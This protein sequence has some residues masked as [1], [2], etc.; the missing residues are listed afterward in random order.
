NES[1]S[2][3]SEDTQAPSQVS[4]LVASEVTSSNVGLTWL[5]ASDNVGVVNYEIER[6]TGSGCSNFVLIGNTGSLSFEDTTVA[7]SI[8]YRY[9]VRAID[10]SGNN[11]SY[12]SIV[13]ITTE[14][15][16]TEVDTTP[17]S[18]VMGLTN[19]SLTGSSVTLSWSAASDNVG[20]SSYRIYRCSGQE[21]TPT[22][23]IGIST[24][25]VYVD[26]TVTE[27]SFYSYSVQAYDAAG[28]QGPMSFYLDILT[29]D[30]SPALLSGGSPSGQLAAGTSQITLQVT[31]NEAATCR[32]SPVSGTSYSTMIP[33]SS[34]G[35]F[36]H[37]TLVS[38]LSDGQ[39]YSYYVKC[40]DSS[41]NRNPDDY[42]IS[43]SVGSVPSCHLSSASWSSL[44][45][46][47]GE[48]VE[49]IVSGTNCD[50]K[51]LTITIY[52]DDLLDTTVMTLSTQF[53]GNQALA[54]WISEWECDGNLFG[55]CTAGNPEYYFVAVL[56]ENVS[57]SISSGTDSPSEL[58]VTSS[59]V[60]APVLYDVQVAVGSTNATVSWWTDEPSQSYLEY[61]L[62]SSYGKNTSLSSSLSDS[63]SVSVTALD[64][65]TLYYYKL[66]SL[67]QSGNKGFVVGSFRTA[68]VDTVSP[69]LISTSP[70]NGSSN[71]SISSD[72]YF[73][74][75][76]AMS[77][78]TLSVTNDE[79]VAFSSSY[80]NASRSLK[81]SPAV[82][83]EY[84]T[85]YHFH[86]SALGT[87]LAGN[88]LGSGYD[89]VFT[90]DSFDE[91][92]TVEVIFNASTWNMSR[93]TNFSALNSSELLSVGDAIFSNQY[94]EIAFLSPLK[95]ERTLDL[96]DKISVGAG[97]A[98]LDSF[99]LPEFNVSA[100]LT[101]HN[102][103]YSKYKVQRDGVDCPSS[104]CSEIVANGTSLSFTVTSWSEYT[105]VEVS[106]SS[107]SGGSSSSSGGGGGGSSNSK[108][109]KSSDLVELAEILGNETGT[110]SC[111]SS[112][113]YGQWSVCVNGEQSRLVTD[114]AACVDVETQTR[115]CTVSG[116]EDSNRKLNAK[117]LDLQIVSSK[118]Y[119]T[120]LSGTYTE[121]YYVDEKLSD[122]SF[123]VYDELSG[124]E[125]LSEF[126]EESDGNYYYSLRP[127]D[128]VVVS[129]VQELAAAQV[130]AEE[131]A[132]SDERE[133]QKYFGQIF[134][135]ATWTVLFLILVVVGIGLIVVYLYK[136]RN[137][138]E[139]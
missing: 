78:G 129:E 35:A 49:A 21:C 18:Q 40:S 122:E 108:K 67:D 56:S 8:S 46:Q 11:G 42:Q 43:F 94:G 82:D 77:V 116:D 136:R 31:S 44:L 91:P 131:Q 69:Q 113:E 29:P 84:E 86:L 52:E 80:D 102:I 2:N 10:A 110:E 72:I 61:G 22:S 119:Q 26:S 133:K 73:T 123:V 139:F 128:S 12:S 53:S 9:R 68:Y 100:R 63:H 90:T 81:L 76:E 28:N 89:L 36:S 121:L 14:A 101:L 30:V 50:G 60:T 127:V 45:A 104:V 98:S 125:Y 7:A 105:I 59:D 124:K 132:E 5:A 114:S 54:S 13:G 27:Q 109:K 95:I 112:F 33:F 57:S 37:S 83:L 87:D 15:S 135:P 20:V 75:S 34:T 115:A 32:Y 130:A 25:P 47:D 88:S 41:G 65:D 62:S 17:P 85:T 4:G 120:Q 134:A 126:V 39:S 38:G 99:L 106:S 51:S 16:Q 117:K 74:F 24:N 92:G 55:I 66:S 137:V 97:H 23:Q 96:R 71:V 111:V 58:V 107:T 48:E 6:C 93:T 103:S 79:G 64:S 3:N 138:N 19:T 70:L 1:Q 118:R